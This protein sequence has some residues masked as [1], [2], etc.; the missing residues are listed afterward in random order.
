MTSA[1]AL[2]TAASVLTL[3]CFAVVWALS[4]RVKDRMLTAFSL[5]LGAVGWACLTP[6]P[7]HM[8][9]FLTGFGMASIAFPLGRA[10]VM[11]LASKLFPPQWQGSGQGVLL[12]LGAIARIVAP[13]GAVQVFYV[14]NGALIV[15]GG[16]ALLFGVAAVALRFVW[17]DVDTAIAS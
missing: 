8:G 1:D 13:F 14:A 10:C 11:S 4:E 2:F 5:L 3:L 7:L 16:C 9:L 15:F 6:V 12:A 17:T